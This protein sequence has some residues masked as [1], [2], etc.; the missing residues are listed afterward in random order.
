MESILVSKATSGNIFYLKLVFTINK[1]FYA[2]FFL[3][4]YTCLVSYF[5]TS[6]ILS[7]FVYVPCIYVLYFVISCLL[8][9]VS[10]FHAQ[11]PVGDQ[12]NVEN[13]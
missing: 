9:N 5:N 10:C 12:Q 13:I 7:F 6:S 3:P 4:Y 11:G 2:Q 8:I 1:Y